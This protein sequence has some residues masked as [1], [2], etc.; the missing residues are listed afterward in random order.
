MF[1]DA[2][3]KKDGMIT[4]HA[5]HKVHRRFAGKLA[6]QKY[7]TARV[8]CWHDPGSSRGRGKDGSKC[9]DTSSGSHGG[10]KGRQ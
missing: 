1:P 2:A 9:K 8:K 10:G 7:P 6:N 5:P 4:H 3:I